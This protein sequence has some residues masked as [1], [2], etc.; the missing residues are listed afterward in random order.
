MI[1]K[2]EANPKLYQQKQRELFNE[3]E[4]E[5]K[6]KTSSLRDITLIK[7]DADFPSNNELGLTAIVRNKKQKNSS[8]REEK[9]TIVLQGSSYQIGFG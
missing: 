9:S 4:S 5:W 2:N 7:P 6:N 8:F 1:N 3:I